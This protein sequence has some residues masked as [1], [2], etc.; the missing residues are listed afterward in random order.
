MSDI[1]KP[2]MQLLDWKR[3]DKGFLLGRASVLLPIGLRISD[4]G[5]FEKEGRRWAQ[6]PAEMAR[7]ATGQVVKDKRGKTVYR[8]LLRWTTK[9]LQDGFSTALIGLI[10]AE[11]G[12]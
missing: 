5:V 2:R 11:H 12:L 10:E 8:S 7:D 6:L 4:I 1:A 9:E 3:I